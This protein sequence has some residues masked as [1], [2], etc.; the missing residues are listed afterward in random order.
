MEPYEPMNSVPTKRR[1]VEN[2]EGTSPG[3][4]ASALQ[5]GQVTVFGKT[6]TRGRS[7]IQSVTVIDTKGRATH[8]EV[9]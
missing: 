5:M 8:I 2:M 4:D 6:R 7:T 1:L 3:D 9:E